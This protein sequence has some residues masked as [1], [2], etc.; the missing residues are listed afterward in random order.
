M[1][2]LS[3]LVAFPIFDGIPRDI[4]DHIGQA[5]QPLDYEEN[6][7]IFHEG[8]EAS[9]LYGVMRG[10]VELSILFRDRIMR[11]LKHSIE[12]IRVDQRQERL[13]ARGDPLRIHTEQTV[14]VP[15]PAMRVTG[16]TPHEAAHAREALGIVQ[17]SLVGFDQ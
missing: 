5:A 4:L 13:R 9:H 15:G 3:Q 14:E 10:E 2:T 1:L 8:Q 16:R 11:V 7:V 6:A 17:E 12:I